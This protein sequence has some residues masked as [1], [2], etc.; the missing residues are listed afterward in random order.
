MTQDRL[1]EAHQVLTRAVEELVS[2]EDWA[3]ML[4]VA[5]RFHR[6]SANNIMLILAQRPQASRVAGYRTWQSLGRQVRKGEKGL[7]ILAPVVLRRPREYP[8][9]ENR[10][11]LAGFRL[12]H[13]FDY[14]QT[15]GEP[16][17]D[18]SPV[19]LAG[20]APGTLWAA[21]AAQVAGA[22]FSLALG[23][24]GA[25]NGCTDYLARS[26]TVSGA[27]EPAQ[28]AKTLAHELAHVRLH[29]G[30]EYATGC[31]GVAE[32]EAESVA[33]L[34]CRAAGLDSAAYTFPYV[35][36]WAGG[37]SRAVTA[38]AERVISAARRILTDAGL[39][40]SEEEDPQ[41]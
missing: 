30:T 29:D 27:L 3:A 22:G 20:E 11:V 36:H 25:A 8:E 5:A 40:P 24:T 16:L 26:V 6:Y 38:T 10:R 15:D 21:L 23:D 1:Q 14:S 35:A 7:A 9:E 13:V 17:P 28:A 18:A 41:T 4:A 32:V 39:K 2:G 31:R 12:A 34:I 37:D 33:F 19:L